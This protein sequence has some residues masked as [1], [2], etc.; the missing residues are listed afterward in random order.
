MAVRAVADNRFIRKYLFLAAA[1]LGFFLWGAYDAVFKFPVE[2]Q[3]AEA[4]DPIS[5]DPDAVQLWAK[6]FEQNKDRGW[7]REKP[8]NSAETVR[9]YMRF[10]GFVIGGGICLMVFFLLKYFRT[11]GSWMESTD[12]GINTSW[13]KSLEFDKIDQINK[14]RWEA[15]G[16]AKVTYT[17]SGG[18][19]GTLVFDDFKYEREPMS[20][21]MTLCEQGL[22]P[23]QIVGGKSQAEIAA[24]KDADQ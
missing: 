19:T 18:K 11:K 22:E 6:L 9:G 2:L 21:L 1:G 4:F 13:G 14:K 12:T 16:I 5:K 23:S 10:N 8:H 24:E 20:E 15:K 7:H 17:D 3:M